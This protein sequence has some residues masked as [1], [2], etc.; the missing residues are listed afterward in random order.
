M[1]EEVFE[2]DREGD[3][4]IDRKTAGRGMTSEVQREMYR[5][6]GDS[7]LNVSTARWRYNQTV[8]EPGRRRLVAYGACCRSN[9]F[10]DHRSSSD[11]HERC[12]A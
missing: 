5:E 8:I 2:V 10:D 12:G 3:E 6:M 7:G 11:A 1:I 4:A 9:G